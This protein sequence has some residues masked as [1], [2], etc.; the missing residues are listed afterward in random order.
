MSQSFAGARWWKFDF[1]THTPF[2]IDTPWHGLPQAQQPTPEDWLR[3]WMIAGIDCVAIT[4]HNG[5]GWVDKLKQAYAAMRSLG[6]PGFREIHLFPGV[7]LSVSGGVHILAIFGPDAA[8]STVDDLVSKCGFSGTRGDPEPRTTKSLPEVLEIVTKCGAIGIAA[9]ADQANGLLTLQ[10][11]PTKLGALKSGHLLALEIVDPAWPKPAML[12]SVAALAEVVGS[13]CHNF[14]GGAQP[15]GRFTWVKMGQPSLEGLRLAL[16]DASPL[17]IR[18]NDGVNRDPNE[19]PVTYIDR[20]TIREARYA[21]RGKGN[22]MV[23]PL[24]P[25]LSTLI[26]GRGTGKSTVMQMLRMALGLEQD[27]PSGLKEEFANFKGMNAAKGASGA[28]TDK[29]QIEV[30]FVRAGVR[31]RVRWLGAQGSI[32]EEAESGGWREVTRDSRA[33]TASLPLQLL[34]QKQV[35]AIANQPSGLLNLVDKAT[36]VDS[37]AWEQKRREVEAKYLRVRADQ[38]ELEARLADRPRLERELADVVRQIKLFEDG[39]QKTLL[40][41]YQRTRQQRAVIDRL[42]KDMLEEAKKALETLSGLSLSDLREDLFDPKDKVELEL[43]EQLKSLR[44]QYDKFTD[45][46]IDFAVKMHDLAEHG[47]DSLQG[48]AWSQRESG[49]AA[50]Y[51]ELVERLR[52]EGVADPGAYSALV[53]RRQGLEQQLQALAPLDARAKSLVDESL[54]LLDDLAAHRRGLTDARESFLQEA[55]ANNEHVRIR[56]VAFGDEAGAAEE[57]FRSALGAKKEGLERDILLDDAGLLADLYRDLPDGAAARAVEFAQRVERLKQ[58][59][60]EVATGKDDPSWTKWMLNH[61]RSLTPEQLDRLRC[62]WP[63][64]SVAVS[65][66]QAGGK[67]EPIEKGSPGQ[68][69]AAILAFLLAHGSEP[70]ALDQPEDDLDNELI[71]D[72]IVQ[73]IRASKEKRQVIIATHNA[74]IVVNGDAELVCVMANAGGQCWVKDSG[75]LQ[76]R[77]IRD[78]ICKV[79]EGGEKAFVERYR[80]IVQ[81]MKHA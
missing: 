42:K 71:Y 34:S 45:G 7:E 75:C 80:R 81:E 59:V 33:V 79:M 78:S 5:A 39:D 24:S 46:A 68:K 17:S 54:R 28:F 65:F 62:W 61:I 14:R 67:F 23:V 40:S 41:A 77:T 19:T 4:D 70:I 30:E 25:W 21:G 38:R 60:D 12:Q 44:A 1:H 35:F 48:L 20:I 29:T 66:H 51:A 47:V 26:G 22:E 55:L 72:L 27:L 16:L 76:E 10:D 74:N 73:R 15:G 13:D 3:K 56:V 58:R 9:H 31:Q 18:R 8:Q 6:E 63:N 69:S 43:F 64:D 37:A 49:A 11:G 52:R 53:V 36:A 57:G 50:K 2:S 32:L